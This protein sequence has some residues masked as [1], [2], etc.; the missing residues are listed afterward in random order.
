MGFLQTP[1][2]DPAH[3]WRSL[4]CDP[5]VPRHLCRAHAELTLPCLW[6]AS[7][8]RFRETGCCFAAV[9]T[10]AKS[11]HGCAGSQNSSASTTMRARALRYYDDV[12]FTAEMALQNGI[13]LFR[14]VLDKCERNGDGRD[15]RRNGDRQVIF[16][17]GE[18]PHIPPLYLVASTRRGRGCSNRRYSAI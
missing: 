6:C 11:G 2:C 7:D 16:I 9:V 8:R 4:F 3:I 18:F 10:Q 17:D 12:R 1:R 5:M 15:N 13:R 14:T